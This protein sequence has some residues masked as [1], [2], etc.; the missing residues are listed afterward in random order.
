MGGTHPKNPLQQARVTSGITQEQAAEA[1]DCGIRTIQRYESGE[2]FPTQDILISMAKEYNCPLEALFPA[3]L[4]S[5]VSH[6][7]KER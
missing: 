7:R 2:Q 4:N 5:L 3:E 6:G 1:L